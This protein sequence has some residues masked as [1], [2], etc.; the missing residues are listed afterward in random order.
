MSLGYYHDV[1]KAPVSPLSS[2]FFAVQQ[3]RHTHSK[4]AFAFDCRTNARIQIADLVT[5]E[6]MNLGGHPKPANGVTADPESK[7]AIEVATDFG[8]ENLE[9]EPDSK[10]S[11]SLCDPFREAI[12]GEIRLG[13]SAMGIWQDLVSDSGFTGSYESVKRFV[14][15]IL[16]PGLPPIFRR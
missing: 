12:E 2:P 14:R 5:R 3:P 15:R 8:G 6:A 16:R 13:R 10:V 1:N 11:A 4:H 7:P 9:E